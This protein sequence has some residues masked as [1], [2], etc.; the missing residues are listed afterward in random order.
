MTLGVYTL[1][2]IYTDAASNTGN[3]VT[4][5]VT[6]ADQTAPVLTLVGSGTQSIEQGSVYTDLGA[7]WTDAVDGSG[8]LPIASSGTVD[9][10][11]TGTYILEYTYTDAA[12]NT[13]NI[14]T[15]TVIVADT[16]APVVTLMGLPT[17][18]LLYGDTYV[19]SGAT[20][21]D[22]VDGS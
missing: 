4:R 6:V 10:S 19:E 13:G 20:W 11:F 15:R 3:T 18:V 16:T 1:E 14:V 8:A 22:T 5:T 17:V 7:T 21:T 2:Y 12:S 9:T